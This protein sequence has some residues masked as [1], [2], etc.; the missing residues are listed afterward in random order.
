MTLFGKNGQ[1]VFVDIK[2]QMTL[3][4]LIETLATDPNNAD[5]PSHV[6]AEEFV[7]GLR[8]FL[9]MENLEN[10]IKVYFEI[11]RGNYKQL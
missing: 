6:V 7:K 11:H 4:R 9:A 3:E 10:K 1:A 2:V 5:L 8:Q